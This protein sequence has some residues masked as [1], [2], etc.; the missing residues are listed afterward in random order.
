MGIFDRPKNY[1]MKRYSTIAS[2]EERFQR[3][4]EIINIVID[5][6]HNPLL[7]QDDSKLEDKINSKLNNLRDN[8]EY[9]RESYLVNHK[10]LNELAF[11]IKDYIF[12][13]LTIYKDNYPNLIANSENS[14]LIQVVYI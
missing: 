1:K 12:Y 7:N 8:V 5:G 2:Y 10:D 9:C 6:L 14:S 3:F 11:K 13:L 4:I